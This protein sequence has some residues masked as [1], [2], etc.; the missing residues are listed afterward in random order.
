MRSSEP[1]KVKFN[2]LINT[3]LKNHSELP[4]TILY[5]NRALKQFYMD[6]RITENKRVGCHYKCLLYCLKVH[7]KHRCP[8]KILYNATAAD[9]DLHVR[10]WRSLRTGNQSSYSY[11]HFLLAVCNRSCRLKGFL[12]PDV[13]SKCIPPFNCVYC[14][15]VATPHLTFLFEWNN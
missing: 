12:Y 6:L 9:N 5:F 4:C 14:F 7:Q 2:I 8:E 11:E 3:V 10:T 1:I 13:F 15:V